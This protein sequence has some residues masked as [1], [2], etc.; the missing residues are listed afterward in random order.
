MF[1]IAERLKIPSI[2][3][4]EGGGGRP[5]DTDVAQSNNLTLRTFEVRRLS[6]PR[7]G[8][9]DLSLCAR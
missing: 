8:D 5:G 2:F 7:A 4:A 6:P 3:F 9:P 1:E